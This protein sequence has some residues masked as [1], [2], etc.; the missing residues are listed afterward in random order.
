MLPVNPVNTTSFLQDLLRDGEIAF[1]NNFPIHYLQIA[2]CNYYD[3]IKA[4]YLREQQESGLKLPGT[5]MISVDDV[6]NIHPNKKRSVG[7]RLSNLALKE[8]YGKSE[9]QPYS[10]HFDR[11]TIRGNK[12]FVK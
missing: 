12:A 8:Q 9:I 10:P 6:A 1:Q 4:A 7:E 2:P 11:M 5:G 3:G